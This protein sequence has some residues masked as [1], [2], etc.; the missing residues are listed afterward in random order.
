VSQSTITKNKKENPISIQ[1]AC[2]LIDLL[3]Q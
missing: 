1:I 2:E 3:D